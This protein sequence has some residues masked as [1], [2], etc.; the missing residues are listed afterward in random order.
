MRQYFPKTYEHSCGN[1]KVEFDLSNHAK[2][3][4]LKGATGIDTFMLASKTHLADLETN[5]DNL[6]EY[7]FKTAIFL[8]IQL[9]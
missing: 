8:L 2:V 5:I 4:D 3:A 9:S 6:D 7:K 1:L